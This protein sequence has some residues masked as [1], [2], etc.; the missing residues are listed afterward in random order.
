[1][2]K[3][4]FYEK[5]IK[6]I[7][8]KNFTQNISSLFSL[9]SFFFFL[10]PQPWHV[11]VPRLGISLELQLQAYATATTTSD[12]SHIY[13]L[14][15]SSQQHQVLN[16]LSEARD[17]T[18]NLMVLVGFISTAPQWKL[19]FSIFK[20]AECQIYVNFLYISTQYGISLPFVTL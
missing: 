3:W 5:V 14:H 20:C 1:M 2:G 11:E 16:S 9:F 15:H 17:Q 7:Y 12:L 18:C 6:I 8:L 10:G 19:Q 13:K 4:I